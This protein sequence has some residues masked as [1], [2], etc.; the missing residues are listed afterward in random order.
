MQIKNLYNGQ[1]ILPGQKL[2]GLVSKFE[3]GTT[4]NGDPFYKVTLQDA[5]GEIVV[6]IW[7]NDYTAETKAIHEK[8][9][10]QQNKSKDLLAVNTPEAITEARLMMP[11]IVSV[12]GNVTEYN[13]NLQLTSKGGLC[14]SI[15]TSM[16]DYFYSPVSDEDA[17]N[18]KTELFSIIN[19]VQS[20]DIKNIINLVLN[21]PVVSRDFF[22]F[23]AAISHHHNYKYGLLEH[24]LQVLK[25]S[26][27]MFDVYPE[28]KLIASRDLLI[29]SAIFH[30]LGKIEE[31]YYF[32][33]S[34]QTSYNDYGTQHRASSIAIVREI[35]AEAGLRHKYDGI[36]GK[37]G[38]VVFE[39][40]GFYGT[41]SE[42]K[43]T[44]VYEAKFVFSAD[45]LSAGIA[46]AV[47]LAKKETTE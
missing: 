44:K 40:H 5:S 17:Q 34:N 20:P 16:L 31:Y 13:G 25:Y 15:P 18:L 7:N 28:N 6:S 35:L 26:L 43:N 39:H 4:R 38:K 11:I 46:E 27:A 9:N 1:I 37:I 41:E 33:G 29:A 30:D 23:P 12:A 24:T 21:D 42:F 32:L 3:T 36:L 19:E 45:M 2:T 10:T 14:E 8:F 47:G 22:V